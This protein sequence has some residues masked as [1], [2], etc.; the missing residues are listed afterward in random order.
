MKERGLGRFCEIDFE[1]LSRPVDELLPAER[2]SEDR[3]RLQD[4]DLGVP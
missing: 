3:H 4:W 2:G 1:F